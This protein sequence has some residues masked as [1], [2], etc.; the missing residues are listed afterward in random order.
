MIN[1]LTKSEQGFSL[2]E[3]LVAIVVIGIILSMAMQSMSIVVDDNRRIS[4]K[5]EMDKLAQAIVGNPDI[6]NAGV[7]SDFGFVGDNGTFPSSLQDLYDNPGGWSTW[8][9]P[10]ISN[11]FTQDSTGFKLDEWGKLYNY[12]GGITITSSGNGS[13]ITKKIADSESDYISNYFNGTIMDSQDSLP[14]S[15]FK[16]SIDIKVTVPNGSGIYITKTYHPDSVGIFILDSIPVGQHRMEIIFTPENDT[17]TRYLTILPR[18]NSNATTYK[19]ASSEFSSGGGSSGV[20]LLRPNGIGSLAQLSTSGCTDNWECTDEVSNDGNLSYNYQ[21]SSSYFED[22]YQTENHISGVGTIDSVKI[23]ISC[24][25]T[26]PSGRVYSQIRT[27][28]SDHNGTQENPES[29]YTTYTTAY[30][31][32]PSTSSAW[33]WAEIDNLEI[34][35]MLKKARCTQMWAEVY[36]TY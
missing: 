11:G 14:G 1:R 8:D 28:G 35:I 23:Y 30:A 4:T 33:T 17:L 21:T 36:Y 20:E 13:T 32:N 31:N 24:Q 2:I 7:R 5:R 12:T 10:Y 18:H 15:D 22:T 3:L 26:S 9:G 6:A 29:S 27:N 25:E 34:G 16:D 19:F